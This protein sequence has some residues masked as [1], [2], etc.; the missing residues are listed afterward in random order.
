[1]VFHLRSSNLATIHQLYSTFAAAHHMI[2]ESKRTI[3]FLVLGSF[4][5]ANA[6]IAEFIGVK[7]FSLEKTLGFSPLQLNVL[8]YDLSLNLTAGVLLWPLVFVMTDIINEYFGRNGVRLYSYIAA[9]LVAYAFGIVYFT[10]G[11]TPADFWIMRETE[12]GQ[13]NMQAAFNTVFGQGLWII[14]GSLTA[15]LVG[16]LIDVWTFHVIK[17][18][19]GNKALWLRA[20]G[21][22]LVSQF[23]DS[24]VVLFIAFKLGAGWETKLVLAIG[25]VNYCYKFAV[26]LLLTP[27]LYVLHSVIDRY[28]GK[29][30]AEK[31]MAEAHAD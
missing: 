7:I 23:I 20:T 17:K 5:I 24:F 2:K 19:T 29:E 22:T 26:A 31:M 30:L 13:V 1:L 6:L 27:L 11:L 18:R 21:S 15:F 10:M 12:F 25:V 8:G 4:F 9:I 16:Q 28:L 3:L 14:I